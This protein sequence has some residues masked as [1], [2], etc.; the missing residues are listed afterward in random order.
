[1]SLATARPFS[2]SSEFQLQAGHVSLARVQGEIRRGNRLAIDSYELGCYGPAKRALYQ[3]WSGRWFLTTI[4]T[5]PGNKGDLAY[6][7]YMYG[8]SHRRGEYFGD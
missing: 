6:E 8:W 1:M 3:G 4:P 5:P 2:V 7:S